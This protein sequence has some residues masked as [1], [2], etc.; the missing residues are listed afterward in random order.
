MKKGEVILTFDHGPSFPY[1]DMIL[2][3]LA[4]EC[5]KATFFSL[6]RSAVADPE[7]IRHI[8]SSGHNVGTQT[9]NA[10]SLAKLS[11]PEAQKEI[12][13]GISAVT[14]ALQ[15][16]HKRAP[17][18]RAPM[19]KLSPQQERYVTSQGMAVWSMDVDSRDWRE[20]TQDE[21]VAEIMKGLARTG[22]GIVVMQDS[23]PETARALPAL[24]DEFKRRN[25]R[26]VHVV[27]ADPLQA[28]TNAIPSQRAVPEAKPR[29]T[30]K[31]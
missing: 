19:L 7:Q 10:I 9:F 18:F 5:V 1:T 15:G 12:S 20:S 23:Q 16:E 22:S 27:A 30:S 24:L 14:A 6:G 21:I 26:I 25:F 8:A 13:E 2:Q 3:A 17:F 28:G 31:R 29:R 11:L 4:R